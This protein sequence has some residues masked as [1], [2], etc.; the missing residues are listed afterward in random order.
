VQV[1]VDLGK[2][3]RAHVRCEVKVE[4]EIAAHVEIEQRRIEA[5]D[6]ATCVPRASEIEAQCVCVRGWIG[7]VDVADR[8]MDHPKAAGRTE[9]AERHVGS[10]A[11]VGLARVEIE[12]ACI[13]PDREI[14]IVGQIGLGRAVQRQAQSGHAEITRREGHARVASGIE[15]QTDIAGRRIDSRGDEP[16][17]PLAEAGDRTV[18]LVLKPR[19]HLAG[20]EVG[21][22]RK[23]GDRIDRVVDHRLELGNRLQRGCRR[24]QML[25]DDRQAFRIDG[26]L[27]H[28]FDIAEHIVNAVFDC[29]EINLLHNPRHRPPPPQ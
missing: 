9:I 18:D 19:L 12:T 28:I 27:K 2:R 22:L 8:V 25:A 11:D 17:K 26:E 20:S 29:N 21:K 1:R 16:R 6:E 13:E 15:G 7:I 4:V 14:E 5:A 23:V 3:G 10:E 24:A